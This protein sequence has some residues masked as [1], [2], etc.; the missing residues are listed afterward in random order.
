[1][2]L[3]MESQREQGWPDRMVR[4]VGALASYSNIAAEAPVKRSIVPAD[5][6]LRFRRCLRAR[7][8]FAQRA[9]SAA[10]RVRPQE[11]EGQGVRALRGPRRGLPRRGNGGPTAP[12]LVAF[13]IAA[14]VLP[15]R[16]ARDRRGPAPDLAEAPTPPEPPLP[17]GA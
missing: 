13:V 16:R 1:M 6:F 10:G 7:P 8:A 15:R 3:R 14:Q 9:G 17:L 4:A 11:D 2:W 5:E 12:E